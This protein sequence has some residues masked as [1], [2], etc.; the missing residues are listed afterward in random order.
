MN[1]ERIL[2]WLHVGVFVGVIVIVARLVFDSAWDKGV[3][4]VDRIG[5]VV[6]ALAAFI[7]LK[8]LNPDL[9]ALLSGNLSRLADKETSEI[10]AN[11]FLTVL[12]I[13]ASAVSLMEPR[14]ASEKEP[15]YIEAT[16]NS[17][18]A[19]VTRIDKRTQQMDKKLDALAPLGEEVLMQHIKGIWGEDHCRV[20]YNY[21]FADGGLIANSIKNV[22][23]LKPSHWKGGDLSFK[24]GVLGT[25]TKEND[26]DLFE[27]GSVSFTYKSEAGVETLDRNDQHERVVTHFTRC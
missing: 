23:P 18:Y 10:A 13:M 3:G 14:A 20:T 7:M 9:R 15:G 27:G 1:R 6:I 16:V 5:L 4:W 22:P 26:Y 24:G 11:L 25:T 8:R 17:I 21:S 12:G 19:I 2:H